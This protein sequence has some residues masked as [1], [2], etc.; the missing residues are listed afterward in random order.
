MFPFGHLVG[1]WFIGKL[2]EMFSGTNISRTG[3]IILF[4][5]SLLPDADLIL[6]WLS[7]KKIH[8]KFTHSIFFIII[9]STIT[10]SLLKIINLEVNA[11]FISLGILSHLTLDMISNYGIRF[12]WPSKIWISFNGISKEPNFKKLTKEKLIF[13]I[14]FWMFDSVIGILWLSYLYFTGKII[15]S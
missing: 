2:F 9:I 6:E 13:Q 5:G 11:T 10:F 15:L 1:G 4:F 14:K 8:R 7:K 12:F 3:W